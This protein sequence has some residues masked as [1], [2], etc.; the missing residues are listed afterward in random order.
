MTLVERLQRA[1]ADSP[2][3]LRPEYRDAVEAGAHPLTGHCYIVTEALWYA[4]GK[5]RGYWTSEYVRHE[6]GTHWYLRHRQTGVVCDPTAAQFSE[7]PPYEKGCGCG[8]LTARISRRA[9]ALSYR[10]GLCP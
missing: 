5:E 7:P 4:L 2:D 10:A 6:G 9:K 1:A 3:L 8:F